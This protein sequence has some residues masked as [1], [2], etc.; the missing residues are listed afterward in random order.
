MVFDVKIVDGELWS[1]DIVFFEKLK[2]LGEK[3]YLVPN[4]TLGHT[5]IKR[6]TGNFS[7]WV[8]ENLN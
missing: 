1:E 6:W 4:M 3:I 8:D 7:D 5:G 2:A